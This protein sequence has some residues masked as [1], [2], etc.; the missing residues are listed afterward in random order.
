MRG[1]YQITAQHEP[2]VEKVGTR[3]EQRKR[4][5]EH[6]RVIHDTHVPCHS[7]HAIRKTQRRRYNKIKKKWGNHYKIGENY[8]IQ[9]NTRLK[10]TLHI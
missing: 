2:T 7:T 4:N 1:H 5:T 8:Y 10:T 6:A 3:V 9:S